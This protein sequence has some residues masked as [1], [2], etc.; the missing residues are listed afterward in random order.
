MA[1]AAVAAM[2]SRLAAAARAGRL[3]Q[4]LF[5]GPLISVR[6]S[7]AAG[8]RRS[9]RQSRLQVLAHRLY[10]PAQQ[11]ENDAVSSRQCDMRSQSHTLPK[12]LALLD[13][14]IRRRTV[15][16]TLRSA[17]PWYSCVARCVLRLELRL[18][19]IVV[20]LPAPHVG[21]RVRLRDVC[22]ESAVA[23][24]RAQR[25]ARCHA[26]WVPAADRRLMLRARHAGAAPADNR[27]TPTHRGTCLVAVQSAWHTRPASP[28]R[29]PGL[30]ARVGATRNARASRSLARAL[31]AA[32]MPL[33]RARLGPATM[34]RA[35]LRCLSNGARFVQ[36]A[37]PCPALRA[38][39]LGE[40]ARAA[41]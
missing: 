34:A 7:S 18:R 13:R 21:S 29:R 1:G 28:G 22:R 8:R 35:A 25:G 38:R 30:H 39:P 33:L 12:L 14:R 19:A 26:R 31:Y 37:L 27:S 2:T 5:R 4:F 6:A 36:R 9:S 11:D 20:L 40:R 32:R 10:A 17:R 3:V 16:L 23:C 41:H 15:L 24:W